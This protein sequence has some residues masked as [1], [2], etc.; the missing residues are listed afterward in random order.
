MKL[1]LP[2]ALLGAILT[3]LPSLSATTYTPSTS[4]GNVM[5]VGDSITHGYGSASY[6]WALHKIFADNGIS[7][8]SVGVNTGNASGG[9]AS[10][11]IYGGVSFNNVHSA[12][13]SARAYEIA[14]RKKGGRFGNSNIQNWLGQSDIKNDGN[15]YTGSIFDGQTGNQ[16]LPDNFFLM[17]GTNDLLSESAGT[18]EQRAET[19]QGDVQTIVNSMKLAN[20]EANIILT[21]IPC[22]TTH[23]NNNTDSIHQAVADYNTTLQTWVNDQTNVSLIDVNKGIID[24]ASDKPFFGVTSMFNRPG[25]DGLH[26]NAQGDLIIGGNIAKGMGYAGRTAGQL[27]KGN[28]QLDINF[29]ENGSLSIGNIADLTNKGFQSTNISIANNK[30]NFG[31]Q[32]LSSLSYTWA[33]DTDL[34]KGFTF[35]MNLSLGNGATDGWNT[36]D[37]FSVSLGTDSFYGTLNVNEAYIQWGSTILYSTDM[38][39][40]TENIR[41]A[42][43]NGDAANGLTQGYY[44]WLGDMLI[45]EGLSVTQGSGFNGLTIQ[46]NGSGNASLNDIALNGSGSYAPTSNGMQNGDNSYIAN[47]DNGNMGMQPG[48]VEW[49]TEGFTAESTNLIASGVF[50]IRENITGAVSG[51]GNIIS[52]TVTSGSA[53]YIY[54]NYGNYTGDV[55]A[56]IS[57]GS[58]SAWIGAH[59]N[60]TL[61]GDVYLRLTDNFTGTKTVFGGVNADKINGNVYIELSAANATYTSF[62]GNVGKEASVAGS[63]LTDITGDVSIV[64]NAGN[65]QNQV[66]AG[67]HT[68]GKTIDGNTFMYVNGGT[69]GSDV[70][71]GGLVG[72]ITGNTTT[73]ISGGTILGNIYGGGKGGT[74]QGTTNV[75]ID[76]NKAII[77]NGDT[78]GTISAG[79][80]TA[81]INGDSSVTIANLSAGNLENGFDKFAG[82]ISG[83]NK[84]QDSTATRSL[85]LDHVTL[86]SFK[87]TLIN[88]DSVMV[89][90]GTDTSLTSLGGATHLAIDATSRL[91]FTSYLDT[92]LTSTELSGAIAFDIKD[93]GTFQLGGLKGTID[94]SFINTGKNK[95]FVLELTQGIA[96]DGDQLLYAGQIYGDGQIVKSG[97]HHL[98]IGGLVQA[99][100]LTVN[101]GQLTLTNS[102]NDIAGKLTVTNQSSLHLGAVDDTKSISAKITMVDTLQ[103]DEGSSI[104]LK[105]NHILSILNKEGT[106]IVMNGDITGKGLLDIDKGKFALGTGTLDETLSVSTSKE[107]TFSIN[108]NITL[109][110]ILSSGTLDLGQNNTLTLGGLSSK[111]EGAIEGS[112]TIIQNG[113]DTSTTL[114]GAGNNQVDL[115]LNQGS[116][117]LSGG[118][119]SGAL[120]YGNV[121]IMQGSLAL[122]DGLQK[123]DATFTSLQMDSGTTLKV[124]YSEGTQAGISSPVAIK[125]EGA[126]QLGDVALDITTSV[127]NFTDYDP[128]GFQF[129]LIEGAT[130]EASIGSYTLTMGFLSSLFN[131][132]VIADGTDIV[133]KGKLSTDDYFTQAGGTHN[134]MSAGKLM[135]FARNFIATDSQSVLYALA[136]AV[137]RD[138]DNGKLDSANKKLSASVGTSLTSMGLAQHGAM[139]EQM[140]WIRNR[141]VTMGLPQNV[142]YDKDDIPSYNMWVQGTGSYKNLSESIDESGYSLSTWGSTV[143]FDVNVSEVWTLG[144]A[145][146]ANFGTLHAKAADSAKGDLDSYYLNFFARAQQKAWSQTI[147]LTGSWSRAKLDRD[148]NYDLGSY[149]THGKTD[150]KG[151]AAMYELAYDFYLNE[152][153]SCILQPIFNASI[154]STRMDGYDESA[155]HNAGLKVGNQ[156]MTT[157]TLAMGGRIMGLFGNNLFGRESYGEFRLNVA[158]DM[159]DDRSTADMAYLAAPGMG[160]SIRSTKVG[161][162]ALQMGAALSVPINNQ[163]SF[164]V[165]VNADFRNKQESVNGSLGYRY[166]F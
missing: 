108:K 140:E 7:Y 18:I 102:I 35:D 74:I 98:T 59:S 101:E 14:G 25:S 95:D 55:W 43:V 6:R 122:G 41:V 142:Q 38:S 156:D 2:L 96:A 146:T 141:T 83:G 107:A 161:R 116:F 128:N 29:Y 58:A 3:T 118:E 72:T 117:I 119:T 65:F 16:A 124:V 130:G 12:Q 78:W 81:N 50:N 84:D 152:S 27:R 80:S 105:E 60:K 15:T 75:I 30:I 131:W 148:V 31:N 54:A 36:T 137:A 23:S 34:T 67:I 164:F 138:I 79:N 1:H 99:S 94:Q 125:T 5:Y 57:G 63:Y 134:S 47:P 123:P 132:S 39:T 46:Y 135:D 120:S 126:A 104:S 48:M 165:D 157:T 110:S 45:G 21:T 70:M 127:N 13:S 22:W 159:G 113:A 24:V 73:Y 133:M 20:P 19:L 26:P 92:A 93:G 111:I 91:T 106:D 139:R 52:G 62:T 32:G 8:N 100:S 40:N 9:V 114:I 85:I 76:G 44:V 42:Y 115:V 143:G 77:K 163:S 71:A 11:S 145:F 158:T 160:Q 89:K 56:T 153:K 82:T 87:A 53:T 112:G 69:I 90:N 61:T 129:T 10:G 136:D 150:G 97:K 147:L 154:V 121:Q 103:L 68:G 88:F 33:P 166:N 51:A 149:T 155:E 162:T 109:N 86:D 4:L 28:S 151:F 37:Q 49:K 17:I 144:M 66:M 64:I